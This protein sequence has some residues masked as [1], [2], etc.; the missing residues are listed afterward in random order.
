MLAVAVGEAYTYQKDTM[1]ALKT[2]DNY[3]IDGDF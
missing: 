2:T 1:K 3:L